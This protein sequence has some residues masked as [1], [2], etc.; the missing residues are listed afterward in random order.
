MPCE[1]VD[2]EVSVKVMCRTGA[3][4]QPAEETVK[5]GNTAGETVSAHTFQ[6]KVRFLHN[7]GDAISVF[8]AIRE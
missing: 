3:V 6:Y 2:Y 5:L 7:N 4:T 1:L 8:P